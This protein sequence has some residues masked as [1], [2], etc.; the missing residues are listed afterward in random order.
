M[1]LDSVTAVIHT[2]TG[3]TQRI[4]F[5]EN[6]CKWDFFI[7]IYRLR[8]VLEQTFSPTLKRIV[9]CTVGK[10]FKELKVVSLHSLQKVGI[11]YAGVR[12]IHYVTHDCLKVSFRRIGL[13]TIGIAVY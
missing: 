12:H 7:W 5:A 10:V 1:G 2:Q 11:R 4:P 6:A 8:S 3:K 9:V 13:G